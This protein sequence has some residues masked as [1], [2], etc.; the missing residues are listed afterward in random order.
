[1]SY[2]IAF[3]CINS[4]AKFIFIITSNAKRQWK[5]LWLEGQ[6]EDEE[7][8]NERVEKK[9]ATEKIINQRHWKETLEWK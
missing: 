3:L 4:H 6:D 1:M 8:I 5:L 7:K 2:K 9:T